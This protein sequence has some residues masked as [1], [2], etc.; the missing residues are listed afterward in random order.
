MMQ[1]LCDQ[2]VKEV[3]EF[4]AV[5]SSRE[6]LS[7]DEVQNYLLDIYQLA[8]QLQETALTPVLA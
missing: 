6:L 2:L 7:S 8:K 4:L 3:E 1:E 5:T